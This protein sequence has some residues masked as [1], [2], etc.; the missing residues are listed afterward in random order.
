MKRTQHTEEKM[1][2]AVKELEA[3]RPVKEVAREL[4]SQTR[5]CTTGSR[6]MAGWRWETLND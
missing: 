6:S 1:I 2:G 3:G 5:R 4:E